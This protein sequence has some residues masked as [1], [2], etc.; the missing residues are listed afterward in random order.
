[1][2]NWKLRFQSIEEKLCR[3]A[4]KTDRCDGEM[5]IRKKFC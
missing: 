3:L 4:E 5:C 2:I 1:M